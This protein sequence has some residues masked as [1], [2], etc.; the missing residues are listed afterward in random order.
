MTRPLEQFDEA[1]RLHELGLNN[2]EISRRLGIPRVTIRDWV[3]PRLQAA[4]TARALLRPSRDCQRCLGTEDLLGPDYVYLLGLYLGD[5]HLGCSQKGV[6]RLR[7]SQDQRYPG[8]IAECRLAMSAVTTSRVAVQRCLGCVAINAWWKHWIHLFPQH[9]PGLKYR[10]RIV[11]EP[12]Q[13]ALI[14]RFP[15]QL[16]RGLIH[17]DGCRSMNNITR[18]WSGRCANYSY[19]RYEFS[20]AS[21]D[22]RLLFTATCE[23]LGVHWTRL[24][25]RN[26]AISRKKDVALLDTFIGPKC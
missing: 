13:T 8:L 4:R 1:R 26:L 12:W 11:M 19:P 5:G 6:W 20:N 10:R 17:S 14:D 25:E 24:T 15:A 7:I 2:C 22:I 21:A 3:D 16:I 23:Q 18:R 9:G